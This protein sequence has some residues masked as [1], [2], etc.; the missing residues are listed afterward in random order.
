MDLQN[1]TMSINIHLCY[2][3]WM[4]D[5][6]NAKRILEIISLTIIPGRL[7]RTTVEAK[8]NKNNTSSLFKYSLNLVIHF[9]DNLKHFSFQVVALYS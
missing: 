2:R 1:P 4:Q 5:R 8:V 6:E 9:A 3:K 7:T